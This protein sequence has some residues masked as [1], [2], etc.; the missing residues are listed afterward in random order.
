MLLAY[1][2]LK[3]KRKNSKGRIEGRDVKERG[4]VHM[5]EK[6]WEGLKERKR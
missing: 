1:E 2:G 4:G 5:E 6:E 3:R